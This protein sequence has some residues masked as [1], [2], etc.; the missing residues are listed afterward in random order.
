[1]HN[2][3]AA[4]AICLTAFAMSAA[5]QSGTVPLDNGTAPSGL[6]NSNITEVNGNVGIGTTT[7]TVGILSVQTGTNLASLYL[8]GSNLDP[9]GNPPLTSMVNG[10]LVI[11]SNRTAGFVESDFIN[12]Y[13]STYYP[14]GFAF[15]GNDLKTN[16]VTPLMRIVGTSGNVGIGTTGPSLKLDVVGTA[17]YPANSGTTENGAARFEVSAASTTVLDIGQGNSGAYPMWLQS[18]YSNNLAL[19]APLLL[20]PNGGNIGIGTPSPNFMLDV[21]GQIRS[22]SGGFV[23]PDGTSQ[24]TAYTASAAALVSLMTQSNGYIGIG[25]N[26]PQ[27]LLDIAGNVGSGGNI[28]LFN[29]T[30]SNSVLHTVAIGANTTRAAIGTTTNN[31]FAIFT[32]NGQDNLRIQASTG[33]VGIGTTAP[34]Y[35]LDVAGQIRSSSGG[36]V[37][38][39]GTTQTTAFIPANCGAD[40][41]ESVGVTGDRTAYQPGDVLVID[42]N[43]PGKFLKANQPYSTMVA[44][45][46][47]TKP[48]YVGRLQPASDPASAGEIPMAMVGRVPTKV[49]AENGPIKVGDLLV[50]SSTRGYAMKGTDHDKM[51]GAVVGKALAPLDSGTGTILVLVTLQ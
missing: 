13:D 50:T 2:K 48:G 16:T 45:I 49:S 9:A 18:V 37:F 11:G 12:A 47:S 25:T 3:I 42:P 36:V 40:Y 5:A 34:A 38:P 43:A 29:L 51:L 10:G 30:D 15:Y 24:T 19:T 20:N 4:V 33:N 1:M 8:A 35:K 26:S 32:N 44:G 21:A 28:V 14:G 39:D 31:D 23:F 17:G 46:Y 27:A 22:S 41:A 6:T 7:P